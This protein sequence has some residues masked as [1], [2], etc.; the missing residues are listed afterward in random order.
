M[1]A[2]VINKHKTP[3]T[4]STE[5]NPFFWLILTAIQGRPHTEVKM[6]IR[7][8]SLE[9]MEKPFPSLPQQCL[10]VYP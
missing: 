6:A 8:V 2:L 3:C 5:T 9:D 7:V 4:W 10:T 1:A